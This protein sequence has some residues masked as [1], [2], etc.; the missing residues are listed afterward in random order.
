MLGDRENLP[1]WTS[2]PLLFTYQNTVNVQA[3][4]FTFAGTTKAAFTPSRPLLPN[5]LYLFHTLDFACDADQGDYQGAIATQPQFSMY[6]QSQASAPALREPIVLPKF[7]NTIPYRLSILGDKLLTDSYPL[8]SAS[9]QPQGF[10]YNRLLGA[11]SGVITLTNALLGKTSLTMTLIFSVQEV[12]DVN[13]IN[14][15]KARAGVKTQGAKA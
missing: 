3:G 7:Y 1:Y 14:E 11:I 4:S 10:T 8:S 5:A 12:V 9:P 13:F 2:P 15:F 6:V